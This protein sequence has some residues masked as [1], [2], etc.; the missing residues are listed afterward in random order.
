MPERGSERGS[1]RAGLALIVAAGMVCLMATLAAAQVPAGGTFSDDGGNVHEADI[2]VIA[3]AGITKGCNPPAND[4]YCPG[5]PVTRGEM[6]ALLARAFDVPS[7]PGADP[8]TD[9]DKSIFEQDIAAIAA[10]GITKGCNPPAN[11]RF[12]PAEPVTRD[13]MAAFL[14]RALDL[15]ASDPSID[16]VDDDGSQFEADI[17]KLATAGIT[18]GCNPPVNDR[19]CPG[20]Q[21]RRDQMASFLARAIEPGLVPPPTTQPPTTT[22]PPPSTS[23]TTTTTAVVTTTTTTAPGTTTTTTT[24]TTS[25][26]TTTTTTSTTTTTLPP[27]GS[28]TATQAIGTD[29]P[30]GALWVDDF[31]GDDG[32][33]LKPQYAEYWAVN[34]APTFRIEQGTAC[35]PRVSPGSLIYKVLPSIPVQSAPVD[36]T[37]RFQYLAEPFRAWMLAAYHSQT[38]GPQTGD[39]E[40]DPDP[41]SAYVCY[42]NHSGNLRIR[43]LEGGNG[44][45]VF[46]QAVQVTLEN[47]EWYWM[48]CRVHGQD[49]KARVWKA[50]TQEPAL[51]AIERTGDGTRTSGPYGFGADT[52]SL[53]DIRIDDFS[54]RLAP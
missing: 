27:A 12:C 17:E 43:R 41:A 50:G 30:G 22:S 25:P 6:A 14:V 16:F 37:F 48:K 28:C 44:G 15:A 46:G 5:D 52:T 54:I 36:L 34:P 24:T 33:T 3:A 1:H 7:A 9:D 20:D 39:P 13:Q 45:V 8:F 31:A 38:S 2:E 51:W 29:L 19:F 47:G 4:R 32:D 26:P 53:R 35:K 42:V 21:V 23:S 11:D 18:K 49:M 40:P 10:V